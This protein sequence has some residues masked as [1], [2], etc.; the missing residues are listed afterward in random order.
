[1]R[2]IRQRIL[3]ILLMHT[4][5]FM[6]ALDG[7]GTEKLLIGVRIYFSLNGW[8][9][10]RGNEMSYDL[11]D[12]VKDGRKVMF[13]HFKNNELWYVTETNFAFPV[14]IYDIGDATFLNVDK[15]ILFLRYIRQHIKLLEKPEDQSIV[16]E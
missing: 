9:L 14:P 7:T 3:K 5:P 13:T 11:K 16:S 10:E 8:P 12:M 4:K 1:M 2:K 6:V 15:A